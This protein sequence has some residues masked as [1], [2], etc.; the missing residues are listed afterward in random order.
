MQIVKMHKKRK[1]ELVDKSEGVEMVLTGAKTHLEEK[2][3]AVEMK[4]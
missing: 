4:L 1:E 3:A 2:M